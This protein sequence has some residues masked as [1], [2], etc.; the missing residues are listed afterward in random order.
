MCH[1]P[2]SAHILRHHAANAECVGRS[3]RVFHL[4]IFV[5]VLSHD[6]MHVIGAVPQNVVQAVEVILVQYRVGTSGDNSQFDGTLSGA[7]TK[8]QT[9]I[10]MLTALGDVLVAE[11]LDD[12]KEL[13]QVEVL[14]TGNN[15]DHVIESILLVPT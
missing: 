4:G 3:F 14:L 11:K 6:I 7:H 5:F 10:D 8:D 13:L 9:K 15:V 12:L 2:L 1:K